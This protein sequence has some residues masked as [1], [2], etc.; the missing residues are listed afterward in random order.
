M[1]RVGFSSVPLCEKVVADM[2]RVLS[3]SRDHAFDVVQHGNALRL[4]RA[5]VPIMAATV[6]K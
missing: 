2:M 4:V 3:S 1:S 5:G 6:W